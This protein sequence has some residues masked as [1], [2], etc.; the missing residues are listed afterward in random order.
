MWDHPGSLGGSLEVIAICPDTLTTITI[1]N[2]YS[3]SYSF[4]GMS[5]N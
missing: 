4:G 5:S 2:V 3:Y 1:V